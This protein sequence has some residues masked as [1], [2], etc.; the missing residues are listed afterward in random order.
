MDLH[1]FSAIFLTVFLGSAIHFF[2]AA[3]AI[4]NAISAAVGVRIRSLPVYKR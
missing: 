4:L 3:A 2:P 1:I